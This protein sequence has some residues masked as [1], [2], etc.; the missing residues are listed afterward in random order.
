MSSKRT[1]INQL[2]GSFPGSSLFPQL[3]SRS[4]SYAS[5]GILIS[6]LRFDQSRAELERRVNFLL[7]N[8]HA[9]YWNLYAAYVSLYVNDQGLRQSHNAW[10]IA[11]DKFA[12]NK[13]EIDMYFVEG[14]SPE[15]HL[16]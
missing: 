8:V 4:S 7:L 2:R 14:L 10:R 13:G 15:Q 9:A 3:N 12:E 16:R 1:E 5:E 11:N 6:R